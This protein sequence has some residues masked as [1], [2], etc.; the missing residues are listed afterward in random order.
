MVIVNVNIIVVR[1]VA[2]SLEVAGV[3][4]VKVVDV[5]VERRESDRCLEVWD[6]LGIF[7]CAPLWPIERATWV[8]AEIANYIRVSK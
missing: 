7:P 8:I 5:K 4:S 3:C 2:E 6:I 1:Q